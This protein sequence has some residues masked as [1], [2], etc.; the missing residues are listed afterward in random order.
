MAATVRT[1][2]LVSE[3]CKACGLCIAFCPR[4]VLAAEPVTGRVR[5]ERP[6]ECNGCRR[7][8]MLCPDFAIAVEE[9]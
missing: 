9:R 4:Q 1:I 3:W 8:E 2:E 7:C 5:A 6:E